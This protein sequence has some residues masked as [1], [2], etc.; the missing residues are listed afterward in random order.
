[1]ALNRRKYYRRGRYMVE[2]IA[3]LA[4]ATWD[5]FWSVAR[6]ILSLFLRSTTW[7]KTDEVSEPQEN[8]ER[9]A[10]IKALVKLGFSQRDAM[11]RTAVIVSSS[12]DPIDASQ[13]VNAVLRKSSERSS[14]P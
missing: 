7:R 13:I 4:A 14:S 12:S 6:G 10:A 2:F 3:G 9:D 8:A 11:S 1:M 5:V